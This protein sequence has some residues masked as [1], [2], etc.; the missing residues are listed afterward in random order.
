MINLDCEF[1]HVSDSFL[2][3]NLKRKTCPYK[4]WNPMNKMK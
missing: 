2:K 3:N 4:A 1:T